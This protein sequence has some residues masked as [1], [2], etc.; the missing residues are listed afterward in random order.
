[1]PVEIR[2]IIIKTQ[3][4]VGG[5]THPDKTRERDLNVLR[6]KLLEECKILISNSVKRKNYKR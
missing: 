4:V 6:K 2:E 3:I 5:N 1:M